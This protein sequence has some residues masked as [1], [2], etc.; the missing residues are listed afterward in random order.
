MDIKRQRR[1]GIGLKRNQESPLLL[2]RGSAPD[3]AKGLSP[4]ESAILFTCFH[5]LTDNMATKDEMGPL[6]H[7]AQNL[8]AMH[9]MLGKSIE[10]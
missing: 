5:I 2:S 1:F 10:G 7:S 4:L 9:V 8:H 3:P 6:P